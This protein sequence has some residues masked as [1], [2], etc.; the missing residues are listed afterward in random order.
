MPRYLVERLFHV[1]IDEMPK[2]GRRSKEVVVN[3][4]PEITWEHSHVVVDE[5]GSVKTYCVYAAPN[6]EI[7]RRHAV[8]LG[9]HDLQRISEIAGDVSPDDFPLD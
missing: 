3:Q 4:F 2:A 6:E 1:S 5:E 8:E 7:V 9:L